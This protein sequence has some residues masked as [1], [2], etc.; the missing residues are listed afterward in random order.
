[1]NP[2]L[3]DPP[4][5]RFNDL[6]TSNNPFIGYSVFGYNNRDINIPYHIRQDIFKFLYF[7]SMFLELRHSFVYT[8]ANQ[9]YKGKRK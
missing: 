6:L 8:M 7:D 3:K 2:N 1:M 4:P 5:Q 9:R